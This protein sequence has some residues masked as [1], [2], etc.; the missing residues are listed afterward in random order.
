MKQGKLAY[1]VC[2]RGRGE[3]GEGEEEWKREGEEGSGGRGGREREGGRKGEK[4]SNENLG[5]DKRKEG[6]TCLN[7]RQQAFLLITVPRKREAHMVSSLER[8]KDTVLQLKGF[9][10][11]I[12]EL[13]RTALS[14]MAST[15]DQ[16]LEKY[17]QNEQRLMQGGL[18][19]YCVTGF[20]GYQ[21]HQGSKPMITR[22]VY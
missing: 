12:E 19:L 21:S 6:K 13:V 7:R 4:G 3:G 22:D 16:V 18:C 2:V 5:Q 9:R 20:K 14:Q 17:L 11:H 8:M 10:G 15:K 1:I